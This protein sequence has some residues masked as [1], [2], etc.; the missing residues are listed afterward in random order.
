[1]LWIAYITQNNIYK[2]QQKKKERQKGRK[3]KESGSYKISVDWS[4]Y[5]ITRK[6]KPILAPYITRVLR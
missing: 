2:K 3:R 4:L 5:E 6:G 1:M